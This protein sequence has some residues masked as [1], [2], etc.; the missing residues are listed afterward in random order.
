M[1]SADENKALVRRFL[2]EQFKGN[3][4][5][6]EELLSPDFVD[7]GLLP[8]QGPTREDYKRFDDTYNSTSGEGVYVPPGWTG[9]MPNG[10]AINQSSTFLSIRSFFRNDQQ[11]QKVQTY[12][13]GGA[14]PTFTYHRFWAQA[15]I[16]TAFS[17]HVLTKARYFCRLS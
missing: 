11:W 7:R 13:N 6:I 1:S 9:K 3:L 5:V 14:V 15:E 8:G 2:E 12:L 10:D 4:D 17:L 16:A